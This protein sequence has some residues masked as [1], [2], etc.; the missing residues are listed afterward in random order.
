MPKQWKIGRKRSINS[1]PTFF[2][3]K[4]SCQVLLT[5][6]LSQKAQRHDRCSSRRNVAWT[7]VFALVQG[8]LIVCFQLLGPNEIKLSGLLVNF[9]VHESLIHCFPEQEQKPQAKAVSSIPYL[10]AC[11][12]SCLSPLSVVCI[13]VP[14][15][16]IP[17]SCWHP[18]LAGQWD[19]W[20]PCLSCQGCQSVN[21]DCQFSCGEIF[22]IN[23]HPMVVVVPQGYLNLIQFMLIVEIQWVTVLFIWFELL[24]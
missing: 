11:C 5:A 7:H 17:L 14:C 23:S 24:Y 1:C 19:Y 9:Q 10:S 2:S 13:S 15:W 16:H 3:W 6:K 12:L 4:K 22:C 21:N 8:F 20:H 18:S